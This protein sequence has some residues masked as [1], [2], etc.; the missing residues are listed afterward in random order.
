M[1]FSFNLPNTPNIDDDLK[2]SEPFF[3]TR[4]QTG[5]YTVYERVIKGENNTAYI[6]T[7]G[8]P[9]NFGNALRSVAREILNEEG[10]TYTLKEYVKRWESVENSLT[11]II[12]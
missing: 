3:I 8:Y 2:L 12:E 7:I 11:S 9:S 6:K 4:S 10:K 5:G 1:P